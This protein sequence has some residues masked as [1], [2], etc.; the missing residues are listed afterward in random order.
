MDVSEHSSGA[1]FSTCDDA[2]ETTN[3]EC[4]QH[5]AR[6]TATY[7]ADPVLDGPDST[8]TW[9][10]GAPESANVLRCAVCVCFFVV[11]LNAQLIFFFFFLNYLAVTTSS[12]PTRPMTPSRR[13]MGQEGPC[14][15]KNNAKVL[16]MWQLLTAFADVMLQKFRE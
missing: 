8:T 4:Q 14:I 7:L 15:R 12:S 3:T 16:E 13:E 10:D 2:A 1:T 9:R 11:I 5:R 6:C